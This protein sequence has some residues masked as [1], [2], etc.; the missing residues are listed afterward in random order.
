M[1]GI[2][3]VLGV[4]GLDPDSG[5]GM[6]FGGLFIFVLGVLALALVVV[7]LETVGLA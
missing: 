3:K 5:L 2:D 6:I 4:L 1:S 7:A